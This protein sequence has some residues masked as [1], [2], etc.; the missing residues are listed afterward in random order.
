MSE[1]DGVDWL[2]ESGYA[3][4]DGERVHINWDL[5]REDEPEL[6]EEL[7]QAQMDEFDTTALSLM[8]KGLLEISVEMTDDGPVAYYQTTDA[9]KEVVEEMFRQEANLLFGLEDDDSDDVSD[10]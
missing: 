6:A 8:D 2:V 4:T 10:S 5:L 1:F 9:G 3:T 7:W